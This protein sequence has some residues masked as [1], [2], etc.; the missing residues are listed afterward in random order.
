[1]KPQLVMA[2]SMAFVP[3]FVETLDNGA[4]V[5]AGHIVSL[6]EMAPQGPPYWLATTASQHTYRLSPYVAEQ[7]LR[8][9]A[10]NQSP[11]E[12]AALKK[13]RVPCRPRSHVPSV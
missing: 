3:A 5:A 12:I 10:K 2:Q 13:S 8:G 6:T 9:A 4:F 11:T 7:L 1:M